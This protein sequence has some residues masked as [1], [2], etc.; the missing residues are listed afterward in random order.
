MN[1][2]EK[3]RAKIKKLYET[4]PHI[5]LNMTVQHPGVTLTNTPATITG[6]YSHI[7][8]I[9][10]DEIDILKRYT[11]QYS[12]VLMGKVEI[13]EIKKGKSPSARTC[14]TTSSP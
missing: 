14:S 6:V 2:T 3:I 10:S 4:N 11:V 13:V 1:E 9:E 5:H 8:Q 7:F 12:E